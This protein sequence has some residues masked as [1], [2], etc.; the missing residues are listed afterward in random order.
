[1]SVQHPDSYTHS[2]VMPALLMGLVLGVA[3]TLCVVWIAI[4]V[5]WL[6]VNSNPGSFGP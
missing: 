3:C 4:H 6:V 1:M 2:G 5:G